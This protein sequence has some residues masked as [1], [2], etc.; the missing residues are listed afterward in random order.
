MGLR[1]D[2]IKEWF[3]SYQIDDRI[4]RNEFAMWAWDRAI[5]RMTLGSIW[6]FYLCA[7]IKRY[8]GDKYES[9]WKR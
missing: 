3:I 7:D 2:I 8:E 5:S 4:A 1:E 9:I 6:A